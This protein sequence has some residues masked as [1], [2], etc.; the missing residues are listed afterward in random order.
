M[1]LWK[2]DH[3]KRHPL[4]HPFELGNQLLDQINHEFVLY[5]LSRL[6][7]YLDPL[8]INLSEYQ[9]FQRSNRSCDVPDRL[10]MKTSA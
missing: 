5:S 6:H 2:N 7:E 10:E 9:L 4:I 1:A 3:E 8:R